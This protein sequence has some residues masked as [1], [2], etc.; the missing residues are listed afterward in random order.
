MEENIRAPDPVQI[1]RFMDTNYH[2]LSIR[3]RV[4]RLMS[5]DPE[6]TVEEAEVIANSD[7]IDGRYSDQV[8]YLHL[9]TFKT[10]IYN[11][12]INKKYVLYYI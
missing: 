12:F 9:W 10:P 4:Q 3:E 6:M 5:N 11:Y 7:I 2:D 1:G 8:N